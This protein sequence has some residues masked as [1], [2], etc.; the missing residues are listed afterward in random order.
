V[1]FNYI[2]RDLINVPGIIFI[3]PYGDAIVTQLLED[4]PAEITHFVPFE[5]YR[6]SYFVRGNQ[7]GTRK[8][9]AGEKGED[10]VVK[11]LITVIK[12]QGDGASIFYPLFLL[13]VI[14]C[15]IDGEE[16]KIMGCKIFQLLLKCID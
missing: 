3:G 16:M 6:L 14:N 12:G 15:F 13:H 10:V 1:F 4:F 5:L 11:L 8:A 7:N 2:F 9:I